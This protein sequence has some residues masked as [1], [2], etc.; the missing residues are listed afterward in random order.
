MHHLGDTHTRARMASDAIAMAGSLG[1]VGCT[2]Q[3]LRDGHGR[4]TSVQ[5]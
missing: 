3:E 2:S 4:G 5:S 1:T